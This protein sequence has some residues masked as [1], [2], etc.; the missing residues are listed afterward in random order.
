MFGKRNK[1]Q[2]TA[3]TYPDE[4]ESEPIQERQ[5]HTAQTRVV[6]PRAPPSCTS[7]KVHTPPRTS[8]LHKP[9][10]PNRTCKKQMLEK[11]AQLPTRASPATRNAGSEWT[12]D[13]RV[14]TTRHVVREVTAFEVDEIHREW[15]TRRGRKND[16]CS[17]NKSKS[18]SS[19]QSQ[20]RVDADPRTRR[21]RRRRRKGN[22]KMQT[23]NKTRNH[24]PS[25]SQSSSPRPSA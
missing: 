23:N 4:Q 11:R 16:G 21:S 3:R 2:R 17:E 24:S 22:S 12:N 19:R 15:T 6:S 7:S 1:E 8:R 13:G 5:G 10:D 9:R 18:R 25:Q 14:E 20:A